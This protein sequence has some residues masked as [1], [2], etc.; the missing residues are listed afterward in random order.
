VAFSSL[1]VSILAV[2]DDEGKDNSFF[3]ANV[4]DHAIVANAKSP[5]T[6]LLSCKFTGQQSRIGQ[7][8]GT[9]REVADDLV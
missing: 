1:L 2:P 8:R 4:T 6:L 5:K 3:L 7:N 9:L